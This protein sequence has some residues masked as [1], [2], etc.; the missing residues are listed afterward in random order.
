GRW[1][2][3]LPTGASGAAA[4]GTG[5]GE[6]ARAQH[7]AA[8]GTEGAMARLDHLAALPEADAELRKIAWPARA[9]A[10]ALRCDGPRRSE[11]LAV[12]RAPVQRVGM[13]PPEG[14]AVPREG[15]GAARPARAAP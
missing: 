8:L 4:P 10:A 5:G 6:L 12:L 7:E 13:A 1:P 15:E 14:G 11:A 9:S 3:A 2:G